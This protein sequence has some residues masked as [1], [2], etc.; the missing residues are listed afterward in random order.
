M[1]SNS[2]LAEELAAILDP[3]NPDC[4]VED[5]P[6][7]SYVCTKLGRK[8]TRAE[9][10][11]TGVVRV[12]PSAKATTPTDK[13]AAQAELVET[14]ERQRTDAMAALDA[15]KLAAREARSRF[16]DALRDWMRS[17]GGI[18]PGDFRTLHKR[19]TES[20]HEYRRKVMAGEIAE[21]AQTSAVGRSLVDRIANASRN[22]SNAPR[23]ACS[24]NGLGFRRGA[25]TFRLPSQR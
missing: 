14:L 2:E 25:S 9:L 17:T 4:W 23:H 3:N 12:V 16:A 11:A 20:Q 21:P 22:G 19:H 13:V 8:I 5:R 7:L 18:E 24:P 15:A 6:R 10:D 1:S